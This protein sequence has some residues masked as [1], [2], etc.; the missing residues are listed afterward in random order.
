MRPV[1]TGWFAEFA[2]LAERPEGGGVAYGAGPVRFAGST[3][4]PT[5]PYRAAAV[6]DFFRDQR[7]SPEFLREVSQHQ[8]GLL[9]ETF[10]ALDLDPEVVTLDADVPLARRAGFLA[11][12]SPEAARLADGLLKRGVRTDFRGQ[13]LRFGPAPYLSDDQLLASIHQLGALVRGE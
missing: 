3:Y 10:L 2:E 6:M 8:V 12:R 13:V 11:L 9:V 7:L 4:D 1:V 5:S